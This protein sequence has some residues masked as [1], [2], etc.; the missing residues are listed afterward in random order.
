MSS[1]LVSEEHFEGS[2]H[3]YPEISHVLLELWSNLHVHVQFGLDIHVHVLLSMCVV[4]NLDTC[5]YNF[6]G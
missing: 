2:I 6:D 1:L 3:V 4:H 5:I